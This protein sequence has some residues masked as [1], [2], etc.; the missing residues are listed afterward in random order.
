MEI[1]DPVLGV[2]WVHEAGIIESFDG[3]HVFRDRE[4]FRLFTYWDMVR[5]LEDSNFKDVRCYPDWKIKPDK[6]PQAE[7][8]VFVARK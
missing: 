4:R 5:Y 7:Q 1:F 2:G 6:K 3:V 8:L